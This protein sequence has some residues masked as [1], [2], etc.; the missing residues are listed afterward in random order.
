[1][2]MRITIAQKIY[3]YFVEIATDK[4]PTSVVRIET[5]QGLGDICGCSTMA[6][7]DVANVHTRVRF[8]SPAP[9]F[10]RCEVPKRAIRINPPYDVR[11][12]VCQT[13]FLVVRLFP[14]SKWAKSGNRQGRSLF[15]L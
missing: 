7:Q 12:R 6:V 5:P 9:L 13:D 10:D 2:V 11:F 3:N 4:R 14:P 1:M 15:A 8:P